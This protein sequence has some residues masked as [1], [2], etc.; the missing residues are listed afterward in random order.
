MTSHLLFVVTGD[1]IVASGIGDVELVKALLAAGANKEQRQGVSRGVVV[2]LS[3][4]F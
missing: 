3:R 2:C 4:A 1:L